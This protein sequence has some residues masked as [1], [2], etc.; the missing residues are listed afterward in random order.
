[1]RSTRVDVIMRQIQTDYD[2]IAVHFSQTRKKVWT[3][4]DPLLAHVKNGDKVLDMGCGDG[5]LYEYL[6]A[7]NVE[8]LGMDFSEAFIRIARNRYPDLKFIRHD[9]TRKLSFSGFDCVFLI[10]SLQHLPTQALA[11][12]TLRNVF[13]YLKPGGYLLMTNWNLYH[14][15]FL[16]H[17]FK[18]RLRHPF[19]PPKNVEIPWKDSDGKILSRRFYHAFTVHELKK[20]LQRSGFC[21]L[22]FH[23][24][25]NFIVVAQKR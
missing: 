1:M 18:T 4:L 19:W 16:K 23:E 2:T 3:D 25:Q 7:K 5:R 8:Y 20:L 17:F 10:A 22:E 24:R 15:S 21:V 12:A 9:M 13:S 6:R 14:H 11:I